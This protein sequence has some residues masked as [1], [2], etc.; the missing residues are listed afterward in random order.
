MGVGL[1]DGAYLEVSVWHLLLHCTHSLSV[2]QK[3]KPK[4][5]CGTL[6][7]KGVEEKLHRQPIGTRVYE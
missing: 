2:P 5:G 7:Q 1:G 3:V 6:R 4:A